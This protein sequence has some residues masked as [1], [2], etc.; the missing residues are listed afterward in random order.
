MR[1]FAFHPKF[2]KSLTLHQLGEL[3]LSLGLDSVTVVVRDGYWVKPETMKS[4]LPKFMEAMSRHEVAPFHAMTDYRA[5]ELIDKPDPLRI[6]A[7][8]GVKQ[9]RMALY[10]RGTNPARDFEDSRAQL[11][12]L[13]KHCEKFGI[14]AVYQLAPGRLGSS[15][16]AAYLLTKDL[17]PKAISVMIDP[18]NQSFEGY[19]GNSYAADL[20]VG[21]V[22]AV[23]IRDSKITQ[24]GKTKT[25]SKGWRRLWCS[26]EEGTVN[27]LEFAESMAA[28]AYDG[29]V[30]FMPLYHPGNLDEHLRVLGREVRYLRMVVDKVFP[31][32]PVTA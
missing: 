27:W 30:V 25:P 8:N 28:V 31:D 26:C 6:L 11:E 24:E 3:T 23:A 13:A 7:D 22:G 10:K 17:P 19:E 9:F 20:L 32:S 18:G 1:T 4:D 14:Q 12:K 21:R 5:D 2:L 29:P 16:T 15:P